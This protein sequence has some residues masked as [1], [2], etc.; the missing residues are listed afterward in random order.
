MKIKKFIK[1]LKK[2]AKECD[3]ME[4]ELCPMHE[5]CVRMLGSTPVT[6]L[7]HLEEGGYIN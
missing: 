4:C 1:A 7:K 3:G 6:I 2:A 5:E